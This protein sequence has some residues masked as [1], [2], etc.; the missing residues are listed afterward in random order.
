MFL[1]GRMCTQNRPLVGLPNEPLISD[2][3]APPGLEPPT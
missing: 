3:G 2:D 1:R